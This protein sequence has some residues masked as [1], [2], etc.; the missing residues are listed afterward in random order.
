MPDPTRVTVHLLAMTAADPDVYTARRHDDEAPTSFTFD[1]P[2]EGP[3]FGDMNEEEVALT[4]AEI[5]VSA[6]NRH[7]GRMW[8]LVS[9]RYP[10]DASHTSLSTGDLIVVNGVYVRLETTGFSIL[11]PTR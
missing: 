2:D 11:K 3:G 9:G 5:L 6:T 7:S 10:T 4:M 8:H 1:I